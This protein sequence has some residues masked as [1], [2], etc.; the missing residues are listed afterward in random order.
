MTGD[1]KRLLAKAARIGDH[2]RY[3]VLRVA[4]SGGFFFC[5]YRLPLWHGP[6]TF[7]YL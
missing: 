6:W 2:G 3:N 4:R 1:R 5:P 7:G